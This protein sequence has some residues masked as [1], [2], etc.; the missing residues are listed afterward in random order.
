M[1]YFDHLVEAMTWLDKQKKIIF[2]GQSVRW[3]GHALFKTMKNVS[4]KNRV[5]FPVE[6]DFQMGFSTGLALDGYIPV[7]VF[8][9]WDFLICATNQ[10]VNHLDK[11]P[12]VGRGKLNPKVIIRTSVGS[13]EPLD[14]GPQHCQDHTEAFK[15]LLQTVEIIDLTN[16][17]DIIPA[18][19]HA[20]NRE[21][22]RSTLIV[23][24]MDLYHK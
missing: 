18:Y 6:E 8:P 16:K 11:F 20:Y 24:R 13:K 21:D 5:E 7:S 19:K 4:D 3:D 9:R 23:E 17:K 12:I 14:P 15:K 10:L 1:N 22:G 2:I